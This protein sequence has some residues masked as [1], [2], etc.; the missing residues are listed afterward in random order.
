MVITSYNK[1]EITECGVENMTLAS[2]HNDWNPKDEDHCWDGVWMNNAGDCWVRRTDFLHFAGSAVNLQRQTRRI[3]VEDC[4]AS[5]P[6]SE[7]G[8]WRR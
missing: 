2:Q 5:E 8:G 1:G 7:I 6:V 4:I 3:T